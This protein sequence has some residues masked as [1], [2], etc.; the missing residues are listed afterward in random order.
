MALIELNLTPRRHELRVF[1]LAGAGILMFLGAIAWLHLSLLGF[2]IN[3]APAH[4]VAAALWVIAGLL[5]TLAAVQPSRLKWSYIGLCVIAYPV[6]TLVSWVIMAITY[7]L[8][9]TPIGLVRK[10][11]FAD[12]LNRRFDPSAKSYWIA[13]PPAPSQDRYF[14]Q[15]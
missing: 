2:S 3:A 14:R 4:G 9:V 7:Y 5:I 15:W 8:V 13:R 1:G 12:D 6:G 11:L 10:W